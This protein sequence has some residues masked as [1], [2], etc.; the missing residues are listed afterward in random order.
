MTVSG[1]CLLTTSMVLKSIL[2][3]QISKTL[4]S[5]FLFFMSFNDYAIDISTLALFP[6]LNHRPVEDQQ[7]AALPLFS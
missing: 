5:S 2:Q 3:T 1:V 6:I 4:V 7:G